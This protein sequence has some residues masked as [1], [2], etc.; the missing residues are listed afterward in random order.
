MIKSVNTIRS[1]AIDSIE[2]ANSGHPGICMGAAPMAYTL[3][4]K[5][6]NIDPK[7]PK[8]INRDRF[9]L[10]A[11]HGSAL[12]YSLLH[13]SGFGLTIEDLKNFRQKDSK[14]PGHP[15]NFLTSGIDVSTG[16]LGQGVSMAVGFA[17]GERFLAAKVNQENFDM[18]DHYTYV[19]CGDGDLMEGAAYEATSL[20]GHLKLNK[21]I[22]LHDS[23][24]ISLDGELSIS[25]SE[26]MKARFEAIGWEH[27]LVSDG[28]NLDEINNAIAQA[29]KS[30]K[31]SMIEVKTIIGYGSDKKAG[32]SAAHG[33]PLGSEERSFARKS[34]GLEDV[35]FNVTT[36]VYEDFENG[37]GENGAKL[38]KNWT[39]KLEEYKVAHP[40]EAKLLARAM[41]EYDLELDMKAYT[42]TVASRIS[43]QYAINQIADQ[44]ELFI[45]GSA[46]LSCSNNTV[47]K[48]DGKFIIDSDADRNIFFGVREFAMGCIV[49]GMSLHSNINTFA[50]TFMVFSDYVKPAIRLASLMG[51]S[52]TYVFTHD[53][54]A[55]GED[56]PTHQPVEQI[57]MFRA[58]PN[59]NLIR[60]CD[61]NEVQAAWK[62]A[63]EA[64][65]TPTVLSLTRQNLE[66]VSG[67]DLDV[68]FNNVARGAY[69]L[70]ED[71]G[72]TKIIIASGSE[73]KLALDTKKL[74]NLE[75]IKVRVVSMPSF[76]LF[77]AQN[78]DYQLALFPREIDTY[79]VEMLSPFGWAKYT[80]DAN[81][82]F[83]VNTFGNSAPGNE[84]IEA[85]G[86]TPESIVQFIK[87][88]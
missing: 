59:C 31:P 56:G 48:S 76:E 77:D 69:V 21:L 58:L 25:F 11:G 51:I 9:V 2:K 38:F 19:I 34:Y 43:S 1:L 35:D 8:W 87:R 78:V 37:V 80:R 28:E 67:D 47:I 57:A 68:V 55:V 65:S 73:V 10:S 23:N 62:I 60:P 18:I 88:G 4:N 72:F 29:K 82:V 50:S 20:A 16:P 39:S 15:E 41:G 42:E 70:Q 7:N 3:F 14:T 32:T 63:Y 22:V 81:R 26:N 33:A 45:G 86:F 27:I 13:L 75:G 71:P 84:V 61:A 6:M 5:Q 46:D 83:G 36:D 85:L 66:N 79:A 40:K 53:S 54:V 64:K 17:M 30:D 44:D 52:N 24:D 12:L 49:N 74:L